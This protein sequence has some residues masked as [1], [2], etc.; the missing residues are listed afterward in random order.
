[1]EEVS[2]DYPHNDWK[3]RNILQDKLTSLRAARIQAAAPG[4]G[5]E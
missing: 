4:T 1:L 3:K 2:K 5:D